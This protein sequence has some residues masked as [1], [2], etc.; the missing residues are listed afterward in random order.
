VSVNAPVDVLVVGA[1]PAGLMAAIECARGGATVAVLEAKSQP[2]Q[3]LLA[4]GGGRCNLT[5]TLSAAEMTARFPDHHRFVGAV[6]KAFCPT[7]LRAWFDALGV[8]THSPDGFHVFPTTHRSATVCDALLAEV[9]RLGIRLVTQAS[10]AAIDVAHGL[11]VAVASGARYRGRQLL[12]AGGGGGYPNLGDGS[13]LWQLLAQLGHT[14]APALPGMVPLVTQENWVA[15]CR[16]HTLPKVELTLAGHDGQWTGDLI[17]TR[18]GIVGPVVLDAARE[19]AAMLSQRGS[20]PVTLR[21]HQGETPQDW[22]GPRPDAR[23]ELTLT[24]VATE[25]MTQAKVA[26]GG[27]VPREVD[28]RSMASRVVPG[29][30]LAGE[31]LD[32]DGPCGGFNL[33]WA[34][35]S[36]HRAGKAMLRKL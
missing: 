3:K 31:I 26:R 19:V 18:K 29:L 33:Q 14:V 25:G 10:V 7:K 1:G 30:Y 27:V 11:D 4:S 24:V 16:A 9:R 8:A 20:V 23:G 15:G 13:G 2:L 36:G 32:V 21:L 28:V 5:N 35:A 6:L 34:F 17:F 12:V 22:A